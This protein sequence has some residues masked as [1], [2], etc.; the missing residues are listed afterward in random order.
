MARTPRVAYKT[1]RFSP[2]EAVHDRRPPGPYHASSRESTPVLTAPSSRIPDADV[3]PNDSMAVERDSNPSGNTSMDDDDDDGHDDMEL[4]ILDP[5][6]PEDARARTPRHLQSHLEAGATTAFRAFLASAPRP[7]QQHDRPL[8]CPFLLR[9]GGTAHQQCAACP[10]RHSTRGLRLHIASAHRL[11]IACP[12]C[13]AEFATKDERDAHIVRRT[14]E[15]K[16]DPCGH[17]VTDAQLRQLAKP[18][19][20]GLS[21]DDQWA[22][23]WRIVFPREELPPARDLPSR[24]ESIASDVDRLRDFWGREGENIVAEFSREKGLQE[25]LGEARGTASVLF[26]EALLD[27]MIDGMFRRSGIPYE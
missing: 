22:A 21:R 20:P 16:P 5:P 19:D 2:V 13:G 10:D 12:V 4:D 6:K 14:C 23:V 1:R 8:P 7:V 17:G 26:R 25:D 27:Q 9:S 15:I 3:D 11:P 24:L 18:D